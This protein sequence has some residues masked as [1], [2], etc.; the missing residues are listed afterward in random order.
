MP[1]IPDDPAHNPTLVPGFWLGLGMMQTL[2]VHE[3]NS[4][5]E[6]LAKAY[7]DW[8]DERLFQRA[9][10]ITAALL[11]KIHTIEWTPA[12]TAHPT[13]A[14]GLHANWYGLA[15]QKLGHVLDRARPGRDPH[16]HPRHRDRP[17]R[18][19]VRA[20]RGVRRG[21]PDAPAAPRQLRLP[22]R[23]RRQQPTL[24][25]ARVRRAHRPRRRRRDA[26]ARTS[27]TCST[28]SG[29]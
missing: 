21:L 7:P 20:D 22:R 14:A 15:G 9:R 18:R 27:A 8:D 2:F 28:R 26:G 24:G 4:V 3:H 12:V 25:S 13:A 29:R 16:R 19:A 1:P 17:L 6:M 5:C 10:V 23:R 11:A